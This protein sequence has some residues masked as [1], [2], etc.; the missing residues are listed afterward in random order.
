MH[1]SF[2]RDDFWQCKITGM[3]RAYSGHGVRRQLN[4]WGVE[5]NIPKT[6]RCGLVLRKPVKA[7][8]RSHGFRSFRQ[9]DFYADNSFGLTGIL[10]KYAH[11]SAA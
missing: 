2:K 6:R 5:H 4:L 8:K 7:K 10:T 9:A 1:V 3:A 11:R